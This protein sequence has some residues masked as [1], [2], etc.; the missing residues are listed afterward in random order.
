VAPGGEGG[1]ARHNIR[2]RGL[3]ECVCL[4]VEVFRQAV[5]VAL[6]GSKALGAWRGTRTARRSKSEL[7]VAARVPC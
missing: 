1:S 7:R 4:A 6:S 2:S 3:L 5:L